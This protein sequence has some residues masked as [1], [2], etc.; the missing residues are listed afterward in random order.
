MDILNLRCAKKKITTPSKHYVNYL[1]LA[2]QTMRS[3]KKNIWFCMTFLFS[4]RSHTSTQSQG[5][6][7]H[8]VGAQRNGCVLCITFCIKH[9]NQFK[10]QKAEDFG[11]VSGLLHIPASEIV[12]WSLSQCRGTQQ[13]EWMFKWQARCDVSN[14]EENTRIL[15]AL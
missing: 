13:W 1:V 14:K 4:F 11:R 2:T 3:K 6:T 7:K 12:L 5:G 10:T 9:Q 8:F 15:Y